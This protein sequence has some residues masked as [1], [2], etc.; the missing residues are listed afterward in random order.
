MSEHMGVN[1]V[2]FWNHNVKCFCGLLDYKIN[3]ADCYL[4]LFNDIGNFVNRAIEN[5]SKS[6]C[7]IIYQC[8]PAAVCRVFYSILC[9]VSRNF[10]QESST[11]TVIGNEHT[12][13]LNI[14]QVFC[15]LFI[16]I[17][18]TRRFNDNCLA[19]FL[20]DKNLVI[21]KIVGLVCVQLN[22]AEIVNIH[23]TLCEF[24]SCKC[25]LIHNDSLQIFIIGCFI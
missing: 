5:L 2:D 20:N 18:E 21:N 15:K 17:K 6:V 4:A 10:W 22:A 16:V 3:A 11:C 14:F 23:F 13:N 24:Y 25:V 9:C 12:L 8:F 1:G 19:V 7:E